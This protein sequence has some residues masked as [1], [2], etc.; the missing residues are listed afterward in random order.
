MS[1]KVVPRPSNEVLSEINGEISRFNMAI[2]EP[3]KEENIEVIAEVRVNIPDMV[4]EYASSVKYEKFLELAKSDEPVKSAIVNGDYT[5][6]RVAEEKDEDTGLVAKL[7]I[8]ETEKSIDLLE[9]DKFCKYGV[10]AVKGWQFKVEKFNQLMCL[11]AAKELGC[12]TGVISKSYYLS[13]KAEEIKM[14]KTP[15]SNNQALK[16]LQSVIDAIIFEDDGSGKNKYKAVSHDIA[17]IDKLYVSAGKTAC[18]ARASNA[19]YMRKLIRNVVYR[20]LTNGKYSLEYK[21]VK[22]S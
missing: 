18:V 2:I 20:I 11:K 13:K 22:N 21:Q 8:V 3:T 17:Y 1:I 12:D 14:G 7:K 5:V 16:D 9:F 4:K 15:T 10:C 19:S 6:I